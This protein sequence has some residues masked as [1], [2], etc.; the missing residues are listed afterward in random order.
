MT[1]DAERKRIRVVVVDDQLLVRE[2]LRRLFDATGD[3]EMVGECADG[4]EVVATVVAL[5]PDLVLMDMRMKRVDGGTAIRDLSELPDRP[6]VL[7]LTTFDDADTL[8]DALRAGAEGFMLKESVGID[9]ARAMRTLVEGGAWIDPAVAA[10]VLA[11]YRSTDEGDRPPSVGIDG[12]TDREV[13]VL[14]CMAIGRTNREIADELFISERTV[15]THIGHVFTK[16]EVRDRVAAVLRAYE[17]G[18]V[19]RPSR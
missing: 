1:P 11:A 3:F 18:L 13:E 14:R 6:P 12:L 4:D 15:K 2:G 5:A 10:T 7:V 16:L 8:R 19:E 17:A 9:L